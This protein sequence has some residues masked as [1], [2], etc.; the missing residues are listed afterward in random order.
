MRVFGFLG[1][2]SIAHHALAHYNTTNGYIYHPYQ[3]SDKLGAVASESAICSRIG[4][5]LLKI[6]GNA[7]DAVSYR[8]S[9]SHN[10]III[11]YIFVRQHTNSSLRNS[12]SVPFSASD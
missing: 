6:G 9:P 2:A 10:T 1:L 5:D 12:W 4:I 7:A 8:C 11:M 3:S